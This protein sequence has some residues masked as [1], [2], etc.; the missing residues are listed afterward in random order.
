MAPN[1]PAT[2]PAPILIE[3]APLD[4]LDDCDWF[5]AVAEPVAELD[6]GPLEGATVE[7]WD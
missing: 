2:T 7:V 5:G 4:G 3:L 1:K 6:A